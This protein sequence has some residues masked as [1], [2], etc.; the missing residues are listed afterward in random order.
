MTGKY[1]RQKGATFERQLAAF[2]RDIFPDVEGI[3]RGLQYR[4]GQEAPDVEGLPALWVEAKRQKMPNIRAAYR[5][6]LAGC[7]KNKMP[8]AIT[9][10]NRDETLV[11]LSLDDFGELLSEWWQLKRK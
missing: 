8:V 4:G 2:F 3:K 9:K 11:T 5:Q 6:A 10:A 7:P 1:N